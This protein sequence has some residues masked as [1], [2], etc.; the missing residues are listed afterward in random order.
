MEYAA[1]HMDLL[2]I[3]EWNL[4]PHSSTQNQLLRLKNCL[5]VCRG[6]P[7][8]TSAISFTPHRIPRTHSGVSTSTRQQTA[9]PPLSGSQHCQAASPVPV[10]SKRSFSAVYLAKTTMENK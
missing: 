3:C 8:Y 2:H 9:L 5:H 4:A 1:I 6:F 10:S 7:A